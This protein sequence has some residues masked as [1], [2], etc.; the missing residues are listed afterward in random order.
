MSLSRGDRNCGQLETAASRS[1]G[2]K[3]HIKNH[4]V[5]VRAEVHTDQDEIKDGLSLNNK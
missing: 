5:R 2:G 3:W 1:Y 4:Y